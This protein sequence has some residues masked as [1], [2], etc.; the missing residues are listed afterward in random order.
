MPTPQGGNEVKDR[1]GKVGNTG[2]V[3][4][5]EVVGQ[6]GKKKRDHRDGNQGENTQRCPL[7]AA[8]HFLA[9]GANPD[10][11]RGNRVEGC[12]KSKLQGRAADIVH[13]RS[14]CF[15]DRFLS[16]HDVGF[17]SSYLDG[18]LVIRCEATK[19]PS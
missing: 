13:Y 17:S 19:M 11:G 6:Y 9:P 16:H 4:N 2:D 8:N 12:Y 7:S 10:Q 1:H 18:Q 5:A 14:S 3:L 15:N